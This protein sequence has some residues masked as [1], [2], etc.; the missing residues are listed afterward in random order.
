MHR[1]THLLARSYEAIGYQVEI[2]KPPSLFSRRA[3]HRLQKWIGYVEKYLLFPFRLRRL[4]RNALIHVADHSDAPYLTFLRS[5]EKTIVTCHDLIAVRAAVGELPEH[6]TRGSGRIL[7]K[8]ILS[9]LARAGTIVSVSRA[10]ARDLERLAGR[11]GDPV[12]PNP[13]DDRFL[14]HSVD[15]ENRNQALIVSTVGWRKRRDLAVRAWCELNRQLSGQVDLVVIGPSLTPEEERII[16]ATGNSSSQVRTLQNIS[17]AA[18]LQEYR[19]SR[20]LIQ[21]SKYEGF[22]WPILEANSQGV[23]ALCADEPILRETG[24]GNLFFDPT[25][26][27]TD[28][29][30]AIG[31]AD[32]C[33]LAEGLQKRASAFSEERFRD[34]L[35]SIVRTI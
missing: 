28:F 18:L 13:L 25:A 33:A 3:P 35:S 17:D 21:T 31:A 6:Q 8:W 23:V 24:E 15:R 22:C 30:A 20:L 32:D 34:G 2:L 11:S 29:Q 19:S 4:N 16:S 7:Q 26:T 10:T 12:L 1:Y 14:E 5:T 9:S 27:D